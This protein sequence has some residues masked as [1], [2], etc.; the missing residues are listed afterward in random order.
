MRKQ[1]GSVIIAAVILL[2][3]VAL[4]VI[5]GY[6]CA[7]AQFPPGC[8]ITAVQARM[9]ATFTVACGRMSACEHVHL[10]VNLA[11]DLSLIRIEFVLNAGRSLVFRQVIREVALTF[12]M[13][14]FRRNSSVLGV[15]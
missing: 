9:P 13:N 2:A 6:G 5:A 3:L 4:I 11:S 12:H 7:Y 14:V 15:A 1:W 8:K 10:R